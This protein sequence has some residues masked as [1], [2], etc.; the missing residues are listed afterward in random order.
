MS[1][2]LLS[3]MAILLACF[4]P[5]VAHG[6]GWRGIVPLQST[7]AD[8]ERLFGPG[9]RGHYQFDS[10]RV[11]VNYAGEGKCNPVNACLCLVPK[12][13]VIS[14]YVQLEVEMRFSKLNIDKKKYE[15]IVSPQDRT[16]ATYSNDKEGIIYTVNKE[17]DDLTSIEYIPTAKDCQDVMRRAKPAGVQSSRPKSTLRE[18]VNRHTRKSTRSLHPTDAQPLPFGDHRSLHSRKTFHE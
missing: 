10:E 11:H 12:D 17:N 15:K 7:R 6:K 9:E 2:F 4:L 14:I 13:T 18:F 5:I 8:V 3:I 16:E 1:R